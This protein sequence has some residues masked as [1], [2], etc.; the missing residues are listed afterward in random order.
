MSSKRRLTAAVIVMA[1]VFMF[2]SCKSTGTDNGATAAPTASPRLERFYNGAYGISVTIPD[3][4]IIAG[5][6][7]T[8]M[9]GTPERSADPDA[10]E[11]TPYDDAGSGI[12]LIEL[13]SRADS[14]DKEHASLMVYIEVYDGLDEQ[15]YLGAFEEAYAG[16]FDGYY[17]TLVSRENADIGGKA[18]TRLQYLTRLPDSDDEYYEEYYIRKLQEGEFLVLCVTYWAG[19]QVSREDAVT[20]LKFVETET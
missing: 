1:L 12:Q 15:T 17:S 16:Y 11:I 4:W 7:E 5:I 13:W 2:S 18:F 9:T 19:N 14:A 3:G 20:S 8:N 10:L 6:N